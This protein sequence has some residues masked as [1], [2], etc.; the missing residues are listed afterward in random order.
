MCVCV[1]VW[2][3]LCHI[4]FSPLHR[5]SAGQS[6]SASASMGTVDQVEPIKTRGSRLDRNTVNPHSSSFFDK[7]AF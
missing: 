4:I 1:R 6:H 2:A 5:F 7:L 3:H